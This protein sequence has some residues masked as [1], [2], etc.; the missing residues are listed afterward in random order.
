MKNIVLIDADSLCYL[1][2]KDDSLEQILEKVDYRIQAIIDKAEA[3]YYS[4]FI[5]KGKYFRHSLKGKSESKSSYKSNRTYTS[6]KYNK[7][8]KEYLIAKYDAQWYENVEADDIIAYFF[9]KDRRIYY[10]TMLNSFTDR[11]IPELDLLL[12][13]CKIT[14]A[15]VDKDLLQSIPGKHINYNKK[16][17]AN[18]WEI[19]WVETNEVDACKFRFSQL[20]IGD[21]ADGITGIPGK[22]IKYWEKM[23]EEDMWGLDDIFI[24]YLDYYGQSRGIYQFQKN[25]RLLH[26]LETDEDWLREVGYIPTFPKFRE[27]EK[28]EIE[29]ETENKF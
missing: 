2:N 17:S 27:V 21:V 10:H 24:K 20:I 3:N 15:S 26:L 18:T 13:E 28:L 7:L 19:V 6:Q 22:G 8:I 4:L 14:L 9:H 11:G 23:I 25:Y 16:T 5:S 29:E 12:E 1:G